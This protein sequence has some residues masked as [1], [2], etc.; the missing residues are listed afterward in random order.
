[1][2]LDL[3]IRE[4]GRGADDFGVDECP[5]AKFERLETLVGVHNVFAAEHDAVILHDD[6]LVVGMFLELSRNLRPQFL[7]S[8]H[9]VRGKADGAADTFCLWDDVRIRD[10]FCNTERN[11]GRRMR[12]ND[13]RHLRTDIINRLMKRI[14]GRRPVQPF[15][16]SVGFDANDVFGSQRPF[17]HGGGRDP[18]VAVFVLDGNISTRSC[19]HTATVY[20]ADNYPDLICR[21]H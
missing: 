18:Y 5:G 15:D 4:I 13:G 6:G 20:P 9:V 7:A 17:I 3:L 16:R 21:V 19:R 12:M 2:L 11:Q 14:F 10:L 1:M 8:G